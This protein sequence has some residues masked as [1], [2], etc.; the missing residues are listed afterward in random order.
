MGARSERWRPGDTHLLRGCS[1]VYLYG[2]RGSSDAELQRRARKNKLHC[3][4]GWITKRTRLHASVTKIEIKA[5]AIIPPRLPCSTR[6]APSDSCGVM[7]AWSSRR[8]AAQITAV[9]T[10]NCKGPSSKSWFVRK[11]RR[12]CSLL[13]RIPSTGPGTMDWSAVHAGGYLI[14]AQENFCLLARSVQ[15]D[16]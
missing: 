14:C 4:S 16:I 10:G 2:E 6:V 7:A 5:A 13:S 1:P 12:F 9:S 11:K 15:D 3:T 8:S